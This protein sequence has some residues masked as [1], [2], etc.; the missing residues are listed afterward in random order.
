MIQRDNSSTFDQNREAEIDRQHG[1]ISK[2]QTPPYLEISRHELMHLGASSFMWDCYRQ[3]R[4]TSTQPSGDSGN[5]VM[6]WRKDFDMLLA[7]RS[8]MVPEYC[9]ACATLAARSQQI[10]L[11]RQEKDAYVVEE[12]KMTTVYILFDDCP[13]D[14]GDRRLIAVYSSAQLAKFNMDR[15]KV[16][17][18]YKNQYLTIIPRIVKER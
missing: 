5:V 17:D 11:P 18:P 15:F 8:P 16:T 13:S 2:E 12:N 1:T 7:R 10:P 9:L 3:F 14:F 6:L 4:D